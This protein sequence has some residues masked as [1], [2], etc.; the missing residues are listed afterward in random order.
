MRWKRTDQI[1]ALQALSG[2]LA[3]CATHPMP[4]SGLPYLLDPTPAESV[5]R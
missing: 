5:G 4:F 3:A 2:L 1:L